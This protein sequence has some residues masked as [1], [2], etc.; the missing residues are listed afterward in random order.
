MGAF[1]S[2]DGCSHRNAVVVGGIYSAKIT[3]AYC[4]G[5]ERLY[6]LNFDDAV[7]EKLRGKT[8]TVGTS[9]GTPKM[10]KEQIMAIKDPVV[11]QQ[12]MLENKELFNI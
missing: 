7:K 12:K 6:V 1:R 3:G 5:D 2:S 10:T 9:S 8:P 11:R 4:K